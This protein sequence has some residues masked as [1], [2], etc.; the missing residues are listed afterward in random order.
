MKLTEAGEGRIRGYLFVLERSLRTFLPR[1]MVSDAVRE[2]ESHLRE[3]I[4]QADGAP[5]EA[6]ALERILEALGTPL[7]VAQAYSSEITIDEAVA[8]GRFVP[9]VRA[10]GQVAM[11]TAGGF[12]AALGFLVG[13]S[14]ALGFIVI[15]VL[16]PIFPRNVGLHVI[17]GYPVGFG[18]HFPLEPGEVVHGGYWIV[19]VCLALGL[20]ILVGTHRAARVFLRRMRS[21]LV[22]RAAAF[23]RAPGSQ[24]GP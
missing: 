4:D 12:A 9:T 20:A 6:A 5:N 17:N 16:K 11:T 8:T 3:R 1:E 19:P 7:R 14:A 22:D 10:L 21:R 15:A 18:A 23:W 13:Y 2:V 24:T